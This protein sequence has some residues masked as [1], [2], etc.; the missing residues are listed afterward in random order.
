MWITDCTSSPPIFSHRRLFSPLVS[1]WHRRYLVVT[2]QLSCGD[3]ASVSWWRRL[4]LVGTPPPSCG[5]A[6]SVSWWRRRCLM[7]TPPL[8]CRPDTARC[9]RRCQLYLLSTVGS[10]YFPPPSVS[11]EAA[12][13]ESIEG[14]TIDWIGCRRQ[15]DQVPCRSDMVATSALTW[16]DGF[17]SARLDGFASAR[18]CFGSTRVGSARDCAFNWLVSF[19]FLSTE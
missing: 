18:L 17:S 8:F 2:P 15:L 6:A 10:L 16:L 9:W 1:W 3:T 19:F 5:D 7:V 11:A 14:A 13:I 12:L 4:Y